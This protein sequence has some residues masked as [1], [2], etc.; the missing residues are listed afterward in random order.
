MLLIGLGGAVLAPYLQILSDHGLFKQS[1]IG[2]AC[3]SG[4]VV[5][6]CV[7]SVKRSAAR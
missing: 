4:A 6:L 2:L 5:L 3:I 1:M 7:C